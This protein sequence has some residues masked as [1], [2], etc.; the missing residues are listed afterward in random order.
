MTMRRVAGPASTS[1]GKRVPRS[2]VLPESTA[3]ERHDVPVVMLALMRRMAPSGASINGENGSIGPNAPP[4]EPARP[5]S[6]LPGVPR[7]RRPNCES[8]AVGRLGGW[9][10]MMVPALAAALHAE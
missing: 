2:E 3:T 7:P 4:V 5:L 9:E 8:A 10:K 1:A 6:H